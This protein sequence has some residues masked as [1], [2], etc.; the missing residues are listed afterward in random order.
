MTRNLGKTRSPVRLV[1]KVLICDQERK[2][3]DNSAAQVS[4]PGSEGEFAILEHHAP[5]V[6]LLRAGHI[7]VDG[8][9]LSIRKGI[10]MMNR[11]ELLV[12]VER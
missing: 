2:L 7:L 5:I 4:L 9:F 8:K 6:S 3:Y 12:L 1:F 10:A 11:N